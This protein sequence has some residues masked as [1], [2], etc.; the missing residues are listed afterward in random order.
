MW[1]PDTDFLRESE[2]FDVARVVRSTL[3][4]GYLPDQ[5]L[6]KLKTLITKSGPLWRRLGDTLKKRVGIGPKGRTSPVAFSLHHFAEQAPNPNSRVRLSTRKTD[7]YGQPRAH[8]HWAISGDDVRDILRG[9]ALVKPEVERTGEWRLEIPDYDQLPPAG[10]RGG[11]HHM[12]T[13][14]MHDNPRYGVVNANGQVHGIDNLFVTGAS[15]F[16]T[17]GYANPTLLIGAMAMRL[18]AHLK[19]KLQ[20]PFS[21]EREPTS[22]SP[23]H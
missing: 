5:P 6:S 19:Q 17:G 14:R 1:N 7:R 10:I 9:L 20:E 12:G 22:V 4:G 23:H 11:F 13:T 18:S 2:A 16:P 3:Q 21:Q 8:L 15:V